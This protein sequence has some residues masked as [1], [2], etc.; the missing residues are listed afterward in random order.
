M[1]SIK[2]FFDGESKIKTEEHD[3]H[4]YIETLKIFMTYLH[5]AMNSEELD[6]IISYTQNKISFNKSKMLQNSLIYLI[7]L[8][9]STQICSN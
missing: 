8:L 9:A 4:I 5:S 1:Q 6:N 7:P 3:E 2:N